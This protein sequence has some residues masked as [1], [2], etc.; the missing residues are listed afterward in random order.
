MARRRP[1]ERP[2]ADAFREAYQAAGISQTEIAEATGVDQPRVSKWTRGESQPPLEKL[3][4]IDA[5][6]KQ[7]KGYILRLAGYVEDGIEAAIQ[8]D[9]KLDADN[10]RA[11]LAFY[12]FCRDKF[13]V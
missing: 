2:I 9:P 7:P 12:R 6:F 11:V 10:R 8:A 5:L 3:P 13:D 4:T 1:T